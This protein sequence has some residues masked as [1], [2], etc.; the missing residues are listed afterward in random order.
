VVSSFFDSAVY[1]FDGNTGALLT[2]LVA[3][4]SQS[5]LSG[6]S[7]MTVGPDGNLYF[8][9]ENNDAIVEYNFSTHSLST[10]ITASQLAAA[11]VATDPSGLAFGPDGNLYVSLNGGQQAFSGGA[12]V[13]FDLSSGGGQLA[14]AGTSAVIDGNFVQPTEMAFGVNTGDTGNLYVGD[15]GTDS[16][17]KITGATGAS[18]SSST[19]ISAGSGGLNYPSGLTWQGGKLYV[20]DLGATGANQGQVLEYNSNGSFAQGFT[21]PSS[22][23]QFQF[24]SDA[25][26]L[27]NGE[28]L[29]A[30]L[31]LTYPVALGGPGT[32]GALD[33]FSS[34]GAFARV[35]SA[36]TFPANPATGVTNFSPSEL[37][38]MTAAPS[39]STVAL[40]QDTGGVAYDQTITPSGGTGGV[41][42][43]PS[44]TSLDG[45][46]IAGSGTG[47]LTITG[48]PTAPGVLTFSVTATDSLGATA[49]ITYT[50][51]VNTAPSLSPTTTTL[52][53]DTAGAAYDQTI[54]ASGGTGAVTLTVGN[55]QNAVPGLNVQTSGT[56]SIAISG[57]PTATGTETFTVTATD[58]LGV[59]TTPTTY[60]ITVNPAITLSGN[61]PADTVGITYAQSITTTGGTGAVTLTVS[62][63]QNAIPGLNFPTSGTGSIVISGTPTATGTETFTVTATDTLGAQNQTTYSITVSASQ[64]PVPMPTP[65]PL[66]PPLPGVNGTAA[67]SLFAFDLAQMQML[68][69]GHHSRHPGS[70]PKKRVDAALLARLTFDLLTQ[71]ALNTP[72]GLQSI[73]DLIQFWQEVA[74][75]FARASRSQAARI[76]QKEQN[77]ALVSFTYSDPTS[78]GYLSPSLAN[79]IL[80]L[81]GA[82]Y[83]GRFGISA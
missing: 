73:E 18:P 58:T 39:G 64:P 17:V 31:G 69:L 9:S 78:A 40:A 19:F 22:A 25:L 13:L 2:T 26:F 63:I 23:L 67:F 75:N 4:N 79:I 59:Q 37:A 28:L 35:L 83:W 24:P 62:N 70:P 15:A 7:G 81:E 1:E 68:Q 65:A 77:L 16:V 57:T 36:G 54:S 72:A 34:G 29:T 55:I 46:T 47:T 12:V 49:D 20:T 82:P 8:A 51:T 6:P 45:L 5:V 50:I 3:P 61:L 38:L 71:P 42:L 52:P 21:Q 10:F 30:D 48:T 80:N 53:A 74:A 14:Y 33:E 11:G 56:G 32:S 44:V 41:T 66:P 43:T 27:P 60:S 76:I